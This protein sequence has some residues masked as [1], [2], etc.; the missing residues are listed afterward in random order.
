MVAAYLL[1]GTIGAFCGIGI[2]LFLGLTL[3]AA[4]GI[5]VLSG[6]AMLVLAAASLALRRKTRDLPLSLAQRA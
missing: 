1:A 4:F 5:Y 2:A 3:W 6:V